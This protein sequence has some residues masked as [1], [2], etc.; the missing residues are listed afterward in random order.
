M[1]E[2]ERVFG[3]RVPNYALNDIK[4]LQDAA[5]FFAE[6]PVVHARPR[7]LPVFASLNTSKLPPNLTVRR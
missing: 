4:T 3:R 7:E 2:C 6:A 1:T 5:L